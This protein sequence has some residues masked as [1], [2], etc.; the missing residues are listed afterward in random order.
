M[1]KEV[2]SQDQRS[3]FE[4]ALQGYLQWTPNER[5]N[6]NLIKAKEEAAARWARDWQRERAHLP[7]DRDHYVNQID[8]LRVQLA[9]A[10]KE[11]KR[12]GDVVDTFRGSLNR[13]YKATSDANQ[14]LAQLKE[15]M[16]LSE[17][18]S[19]WAERELVKY[20]MGKRILN[21]LKGTEH[22]S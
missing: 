13:E 12:L 3:E 17:E 6:G 15:K 5:R 21:R 16:R 8:T 11:I 9:E 20:P 2:E 7:F 18:E 4:R 10:E 14:E 1:T 22:E 19:E